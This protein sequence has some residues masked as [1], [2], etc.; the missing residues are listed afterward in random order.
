MLFDH[1]F[2]TISP[3]TASVDSITIGGSAFP[4]A[5]NIAAGTSAA[6]TT[7]PVIGSLRWNTTIGALEI[8]DGVFWSYCIP[9]VIQPASYVLAGPTFGNGIPTFRLLGLGE[10]SDVTITSPVNG[11]ILSYNGTKWVNSSTVASSA[12]GLLSSWTLVSGNRYYSDFAHNLGTNNVV[13]T[14]YDTSNNTVITADEIT[15]TNT[16]TVRVQVIGNS[17]TIR[18]VVVANGYTINTAAQ[19]AGTITTAK[20]SVNVSAAASRLNFAGQ[21]V[22]V[23]DA[24]AGT[25]NVMIG[26][27]FTFFA[28]ALDTPN[29]ADW[30]VNALAPTAVDPSFG[31]L[32]VRQFSNTIEQGVGFLLS[33][34]NSATAI[35]FKFRGRPATAPGAAANV[36]PRIYARLIPNGAVMG[37]WSGAQNLTSIIIPTNAFFQYSNQTVTLASLGLTAGNTYQIELTRNVGAASNLGSN[38][39][40]AELTVELA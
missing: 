14:M 29:N 10:H 39:L 11:N 19:S 7:A 3:S 36:Q 15:L 35:T 22:T 31:S 32:S 5:V 30:A 23:S 1:S 24:G 28:G 13:I 4:G 16:N 12:S 6:R 34:P 33:I 21:A 25:T 37:A 17:R 20:D 40:L 18:I 8:F 26:S 9:A 2:E 27:R 38:F